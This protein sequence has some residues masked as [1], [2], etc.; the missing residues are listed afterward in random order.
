MPALMSLKFFAKTSAHLLLTFSFLIAFGCGQKGPLF[1]PGDPDRE[2]TEISPEQAEK[3][4]ALREIIEE[5]SESD[6]PQAADDDA[7]EQTPNENDGL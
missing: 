3:I 4:E 2:Q 1:L 6:D 7:D 5:K